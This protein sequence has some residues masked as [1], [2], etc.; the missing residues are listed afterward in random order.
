MRLTYRSFVSRR[1]RNDMH[2]NMEPSEDPF[3]VELVEPPVDAVFG[4]RQDEMQQLVE[5]FDDP[6]MTDIKQEPNKNTLLRVPSF[7]PQ[8]TLRQESDRCD[9]SQDQ[10]ES[11]QQDVTHSVTNATMVTGKRKKL[12]YFTFQELRKLLKVGHPERRG[13]GASPGPPHDLPPRLT[14]RHFPRSFPPT[15]QNK[16]PQRK[17]Y[18][19]FYSSRHRKKRTQTRFLCRK[20]AVPLCIEPCFEEYHTL[21]NF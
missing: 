18:V 14:E 6:L 7:T 10:V 20:C 12:E 11:E 19:C 1:T 3:K 21:L 13:L 17:C 16:T 8:H 15:P 4:E 5:H 9:S 2:L